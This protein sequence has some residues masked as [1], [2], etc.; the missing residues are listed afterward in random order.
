MLFWS[1]LACAPSDAGLL[2]RE[3]LAHVERDG[4][5]AVVPPVRL[6]VPAEGKHVEIW[7]SVPDG[8][9]IGHRDGRIGPYPPGTIADRVEFRGERVVDVRGTRIDA[10]GRRVHHV[11]K[12][13]PGASALLGAAWFADDPIDTAAAIDRLM[14]GLEARGVHRTDAIRRKLDCESCH[15]A[16]RPDNTTRREHGLV[17]RGTDA[18]GFFTV[19]T[20]LAESVPLEHY[21]HDANLADPD[22]LVRC[23]EGTAT[24]GVHATC[25]G[26]AVP[27]AVLAADADSAH[28]RAHHVSRQQLLALLEAP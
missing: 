16:D 20:L 2:H 10:E 19:A 12:P 17:N 15:T 24:R 23:P 13:V 3:P 27:R 22:V 1:L 4:A 25:P 28:A 5:F 6:P 26:D 8:A 14:D 11:F 18:A 9:T 21:G 7:L